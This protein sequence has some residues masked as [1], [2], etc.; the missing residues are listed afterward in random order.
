MIPSMSQIQL[1]DHL[2]SVRPYNCFRFIFQGR[3][4][5]Q[6]DENGDF[7]KWDAKKAFPTVR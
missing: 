4:C 7:L 5:T 1:F 3:M 6:Y 2:Q